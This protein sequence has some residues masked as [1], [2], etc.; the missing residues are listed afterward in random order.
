MAK[1]L[2]AEEK[3]D[4]EPKKKKFQLPHLFWIMLG[5]LLLA[6]LAT[7]VVPAGNFAIDEDGTVIGDQF[8]FIGHQT[9]VSPWKMLM[10]FLDGLNQSGT[11]IFL[12]L[13]S[14]AT[15]SVL[16]ASGAVDNILNWAIFKLKDKGLGLLVGAMFVLVVYIGGFAGSDALIALVPIG[17][18]FARKL[19]LDPLVAIGITTFPALIGFGTGP[20]AQFV[21][22]M[23]I[24]I[25]PYS[26]FGL[27]FVFMNFFMIIGLIYLMRYIKKI[28]KNE[29]ASLMYS[30]G[31][32]AQ[33][34]GKQ[35]GEDAIKE[36]KLKPTSVIALLSFIVQYLVIIGYSAFGG[37]SELLYN[38]IIV[39][40][41]LTAIVIGLLTRM[42]FDNIGDSF[43]KGLASMA[44]IGFI[45]GL[46]RVMSLILTE[47]NILDTIVYYLTQPLMDINKS[48]ATIGM[49]LIISILN[50]LVPS[51]TSKAAILIPII[52]PISVAL[53]LP[54]QVAIQAF[55]FG[56]GF[57]NMISPVLGWTIGSCV[58]AGVS[59]T[60]WLRWVF[61]AVIIFMLFSFV[62]L[63]ILTSIGWTGGAV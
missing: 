27:R 60:K 40:N 16:L 41:V 36:E 13:V 54:K 31:W 33:A 6:S 46:A 9:P 21:P 19:K 55:Q 42:S 58:A 53:G 48:F 50:P 3:P 28:Q 62:I 49:S 4:V 7:Y 56:D 10:L 63:F 51:V 15:I 32:R 38:F 43:A 39:T 23:M 25:R 61:P 30:E 45:I 20:Q 8:E 22:Q 5:I 17:V 29:Q 18:I 34:F 11:I 44:F 47:G 12:V 37:D 1:N 59:F 35:T 57:T 2:T 52:E 26:G 24:G 14:G